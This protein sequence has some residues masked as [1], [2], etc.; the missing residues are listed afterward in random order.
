MTI[1]NRHRRRLA[2]FISTLATAALLSAAPLASA[3][4]TIKIGYQKS[5]TLLILLKRNGTLEKKLAPLGYQIS[6]HELSSELLTT[7]NTGSVDI[8][9]DVAD[10]FALFTQASSA[11]LTYYAKENA[12]PSAQAIVVP[13]HSTIRSVADLKGKKVAVQK[14][15]GSNFLLLT[16]LKKANLT[17]KD[18]DVRYLDAPDGRAAFASGNVDAWVVWDPFLAATERQSK[19]RI[20]AD[21]RDGLAQYYR[22]YTATTGFA[23]K[24]PDV[25]TIV[26]KELNETGKWVKANPKEAAEI[27]SPLWGNTDAATVEL[28]NSR[29]SYEIVPVRRDDLAEQQ[30]IA[31]TYYQTGLIPKSLVAKDIKIWSAAAK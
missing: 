22:F 8:H 26:L 14:G 31:D 29:R 10:A 20:L 11:P 27:L 6:W 1:I 2:L 24:H 25:L 7:L 17:I 13:D 15:T 3:A 23:D 19:V 18:I 5:S 21:G 30:R 4:E 16:A 12:A 9:A 28:T